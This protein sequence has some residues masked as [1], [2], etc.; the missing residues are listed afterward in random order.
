MSVILR[1]CGNILLLCMLLFGCNQAFSQSRLKGIYIV[2]ATSR[3]P[4]QDAFVQSEDLSFNASADENG[5]VNV[6][7]LPSSVTK[8]SVSRI[9]FETKNIELTALTPTDNT[10]IIYLETKVS[11]L[12]EIKVRAAA[13]NGV[14]KPLATLIYICVPSTIRRKY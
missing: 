1:F 4:V 11:S 8:L 13:N 6:K 12:E 14:F 2:N 3:V 5:F 10:A 7:N 9:G